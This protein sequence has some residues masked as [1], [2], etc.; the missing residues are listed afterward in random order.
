MP[1]TV[2]SRL[3]AISLQVGLGDLF[4]KAANEAQEDKSICQN[5]IGLDFVSLLSD[6]VLTFVFS[7]L[8]V[9]SLSCTSRVCRRL[10]RV[11]EVY[12]TA[13]WR[14]HYNVLAQEMSIVRTDSLNIKK[15]F[16]ELKAL[17]NRAEMRHFGTLRRL[18]TAMCNMPPNFVVNVVA[19]IGW[20]NESAV[21]IAVSARRHSALSAVVL[22]HS[23]D[24]LVFRR[25]S[26]YVGPVTFLSQDSTAPLMNGTIS[27]QTAFPV[28][29]NCFCGHDIENKSCESTGF[30]GY[31]VDIICLKDEDEYMRYTFLL[32]AY[33][34]LSVW[35]SRLKM[36]RARDLGILPLSVPSVALDEFNLD[37]PTF[38]K[39]WFRCGVIDAKY[40]PCFVS[41]GRPRPLIRTHEQLIKHFE[42]L[43]RQKDQFR[44]SFNLV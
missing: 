31:V 15:K 7:Y 42:Y 22:R 5:C 36:Q 33:R 18:M 23:A 1:I 44:V 11:N 41:I 37:D 25:E 21:A 14:L 38:L 28:I 19:N 34:N 13:L 17:A 10:R 8:D 24:A 20:F 40:F 2:E 12:Q 9:Y 27:Q 4:A 43:Q 30:I 29:P 16:I 26:G 6:D 35:K 39:S 32:W 3:R